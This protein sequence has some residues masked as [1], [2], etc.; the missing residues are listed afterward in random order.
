MA[1][2]QQN[3][4]EFVLI[5]EPP[6]KI[7]EEDFPGFYA[8]YQRAIFM[9]LQRQGLLNKEQRDAALS[10]MDLLPRKSGLS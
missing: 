6:P 1:K 9:S 4:R 2:R 3:P 10:A 7:S 8:Q 5:S